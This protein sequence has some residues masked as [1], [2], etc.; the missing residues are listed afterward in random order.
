MESA[1]SPEIYVGKYLCIQRGERYWVGQLK[2]YETE[3]EQKD[4]FLFDGITC[5]CFSSVLDESSANDW[6]KTSQYLDLFHIY[7][8]ECFNIQMISKQQYKEYFKMYE[9]SLWKKMNLDNV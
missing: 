4:S 5:L 8:Q 6:Q 1:F 7:K 9:D 3:G 2:K